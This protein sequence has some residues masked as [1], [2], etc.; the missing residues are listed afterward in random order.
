MTE[1]KKL[2]PL[3]EQALLGEIVFQVKVA[4]LAATHLTEASGT[5]ETWGAIQSLLVAAANVS[6]ILWPKHELH[7]A[8]GER[9]RELLRVKEDKL[10]RARDLRNHFEHY[11]ERIERWFDGRNPSVYMDRGIDSR[12]PMSQALPRIFHQ[13]YN[14]RNHMV[15]F[16]D[17][18]PINLREVLAA[19]REIREKCRA[20]ALVD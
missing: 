8:R 14:P 3:E 5:I 2:K 17:E 16:R 10:L 15:S 4:E 18:P 7:R 20:F 12:D 19:L 6:R 11:D 9:L 1:E 13:H